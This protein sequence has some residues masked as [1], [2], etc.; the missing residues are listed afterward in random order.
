MTILIIGVLI[1]ILSLI[2]SRRFPLLKKYR[3]ELILAILSGFL[4][5][6]TPFFFYYVTSS[7]YS[8]LFL[9]DYHL[10]IGSFLTFWAGGIEIFSGI[11]ISMNELVSKIK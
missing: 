9:I 8:Y 10:S 1:I 7:F 4:L 11:L 6:F 5:I 2:I 3:L